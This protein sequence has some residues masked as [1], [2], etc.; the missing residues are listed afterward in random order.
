[1]RTNSTDWS[2]AKKRFI[3]S[4]INLSESELDNTHGNVESLTELLQHKYSLPYEQAKS[5]VTE[6]MSKP[7]EES[8]LPDTEIQFE[9]SE[10][11]DTRRS[12]GTERPEYPNKLYEE[13]LPPDIKLKAFNE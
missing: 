3:K 12:E 2:N 7:K 13:D 1:M 8:E 5:S 10:V 6:I 9:P 4:W 11:D